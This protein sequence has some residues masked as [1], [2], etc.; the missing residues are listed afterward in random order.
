MQSVSL[1][2]ALVMALAG[3]GGPPRSD[4]DGD[5]DADADTDADGDSDG[6]GDGD[7]DG[8]ADARPAPGLGV[9]DHSPD[10]VEL[11]QF[12][13]FDDLNTPTA[14]A[15]ARDSPGDLWIVNQFDD[16]WTIV[17]DIEGVPM[18]RRYYDDSS[19]FL[20]A[21]TSLSFGDASTV[22]TCQESAD[23]LNGLQPRDF[24]MGP[25][26]WTTNRRIF[27]GGHLS[28]YDM[29]HE[30]PYC[31]GIAWERERVWWAFNDFDRALDRVDFHD[32]HPD[33]VDGLGG[34]DH[35][36][37][38]VFRYV[39][40]ELEGLDGVPA[41]MVVD[42]E[43]GSLYLNDTGHGRLVRLDPSTGDCQ[44]SAGRF[45]EMTFWDCGGVL[46]E[47]VPPGT[48][49]V[50][51]SGMALFEGLL[52]VT[53]RADGVIHAFTRTGELVNWLDTGVGAGAI[54]GVAVS[55]SGAVYFLDASAE[56]LFRID[57]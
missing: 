57:P 19:H 52:Y 10:S 17:D 50:E 36:D 46:E 40:G 28:H 48:E 53:D 27:D 6:D 37:G 56:R 13:G 26:E 41:H 23:D 34:E 7:A 44:R 4:D 30:S 55:Q 16:S 5:G 14:L 32:P 18:V 49:L 25:V 39:E 1:W 8:D 22:A 29:A 35:T 9:G 31:M 2:L 12:L 45:D 42:P 54:T 15:F 11:V 24:W 38:E 43:D 51:P 21:P 20:D 47:I 33:G 3:C